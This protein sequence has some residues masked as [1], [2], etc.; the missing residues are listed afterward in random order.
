MLTD[1]GIATMAGDPA[2]TSTGV[3]L[4]S[5]AYMSPERARGKAF[6]P[7]S[8]LWSLGATLYAA[9][10]GRPPFDSDN[11]LGTLT[12]GH[13]RPGAPAVGGRSAGARRSTACCAKDPPT[14]P[15]SPRP[16]S[17]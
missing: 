2:L 10:E 3:V 8:D 17:C 9:A 7:E 11:A 16:A 6:G 5:P 15:A 1:F 14:A 4:G 13:L 12:V